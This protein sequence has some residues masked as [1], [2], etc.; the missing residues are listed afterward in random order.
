[1]STRY[2]LTVILPKLYLADAKFYYASLFIPT[3]RDI[4]GAPIIFYVSHKSRSECHQSRNCY[5]YRFQN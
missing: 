4:I 1:M 2:Y 3:I 5:G